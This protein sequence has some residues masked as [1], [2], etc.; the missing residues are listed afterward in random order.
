MCLPGATHTA[1]FGQHKLVVIALK[2]LLSL[3]SGM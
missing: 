2:D 1:S 3:L